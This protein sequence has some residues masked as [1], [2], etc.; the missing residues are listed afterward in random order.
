MCLDEMHHATAD[1]YSKVIH[2]FSSRYRI[3]VSATPDKTGDFMLASDVLGPIFH[4]T[5]PEQVSSLLK[6]RVERV[7]TDFYFPFVGTRSR[8][9]RSNYPQMIQALVNDYG[10]NGLIVNKIMDNRGHHQL[11]LSKRLGHIDLLAD[12][13]TDAGWNEQL[14]ILTAEA[15]SADRQKITDMISKEP[16]VVFSTLADEA[17]D[18]PRLD[19]GHL[20]FPQKNPGLITQQVGRFERKHPDKNDAVIYDYADMKITPLKKQWT[21]RRREVY[22]RRNYEIIFDTV[23][24]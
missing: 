10:R 3:G 6:P 8:Y 15:S 14:L 5:T 20:A 1:T 17:L 11:V 4:E 2:H 7:S 21:T 22:M 13:L 12:M 9:Q 19:R 23:A 18:I 16:G 24:S